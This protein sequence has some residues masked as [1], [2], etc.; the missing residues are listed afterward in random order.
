[1]NNED[2]KDKCWEEF[3]TWDLYN[4]ELLKQAFENP[5]NAYVNEYKR[6]S[7]AGGIYFGGEYKE[8]TVQEKI[9]GIREEMGSQVRRLKWFHDK[10]ELLKTLPGL[11][12]KDLHK[13]K[14][15]A[16]IHLLTRF[17]KVAQEF[18]DRHSD[19]ETILLKDEYDVQD[20]LKGL[21]KIHFDDIRKEDFS[22]SNAG[23]NSRLDF[24][25]KQEGIILEIKMTNKNLKARELGEELLIDIGRYKAYP[26]CSDLVIFIYDNQDYINNK[27]GLINDLEK[28]S[29]PQLKITALIIP[30]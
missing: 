30:E 13:A 28:Q 9:D 12:A 3:I 16:L 20:M 6:S 17:H 5:D 29:T 15:E 11:S 2:D 4:V 10:I 18:R 22:P 27:K 25:L 26:N 1:M 7:G 14:L 24:V 19:R 21:L 23:A 8:P